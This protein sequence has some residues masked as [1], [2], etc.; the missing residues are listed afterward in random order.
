MGS[1]PLVIPDFAAGVQASVQA[2]PLQVADPAVL[3]EAPVAVRAAIAFGLVL[4]AGAGILWRDEGT[5]DRAMDAMLDRPIASVGYGITAHLVIAF[6]A[7][8]LS[9][10]F[11]LIQVGGLNVAGLGAILAG[12]LALFV[13]ALG[14]TV[15]G[16]TLLDLWGTPGVWSGLVIG[17]AIAG[18]IVVTEPP[19]VWMAWVAVVSVG[20]GGTV[21]TWIF[22]SFDSD[23]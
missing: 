21:R 11:A 23:L 8:Y 17:A 19:V 9:S 16:A 6:T 2:P 14:F 5:V 13:A 7:A 4:I 15:V 18:G 20:I 22:A 3:L 12:L 1:L 10:Q